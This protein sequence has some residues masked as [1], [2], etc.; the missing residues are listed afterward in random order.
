ME[1]NLYY[2]TQEEIQ[3]Y[4]S[5]KKNIRVKL[6]FEAVNQTELLCKRYIES[7]QDKSILYPVRL[8]A[9]DLKNPREK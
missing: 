5:T 6:I 3:E 9:A 4:L 7:R 2:E 1:N 8:D